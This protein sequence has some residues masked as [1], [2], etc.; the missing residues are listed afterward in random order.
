MTHAR[1][2]PARNTSSVTAGWHKHVILQLKKAGINDAGFFVAVI[3]L[4]T[5]KSPVC[6]GAF[7]CARQMP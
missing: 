3:L 5:A 4:Q 6:N 7:D 2:V 1:V